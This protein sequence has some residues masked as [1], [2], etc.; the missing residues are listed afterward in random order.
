ML[1]IFGSRDRR[2][3][4]ERDVI[5][6]QYRRGRRWTV[7]FWSLFYGGFMF[8]WMTLCQFFLHPR[9]TLKAGQDWIWLLISLM[10]WLAAGYGLGAYQWRRIE[11]KLLGVGT[12]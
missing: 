10:F 1:R 9:P 4:L 6:R 8:L 7:W 12:D 3:E 5:Q 2:R 11:K